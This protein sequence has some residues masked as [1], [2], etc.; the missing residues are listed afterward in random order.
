M[1]KQLIERALPFAG[2][3]VFDG[4]HRGSIIDGETTVCA[5]CGAV[6]ANW[7][8]IIDQGDR[9]RKR[10]GLDCAKTLEQAGAM[11]DGRRMYSLDVPAFNAAQRV[12]TEIRKGKALR[13]DWMGYYVTAD[14]GREISATREAI[15]T[16]FPELIQR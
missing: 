8:E 13:V 14:N 9:Q 15:E 7:A 16:N 11:Y 4:V 12:A 2:K 10:I 5:N 1:K 3:Y 6:L